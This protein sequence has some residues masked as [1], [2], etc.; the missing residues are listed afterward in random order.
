MTFQFSG[1]ISPLRP[2]LNDINAYS[3][4]EVISVT[5]SGF[6]RWLIHAKATGTGTSPLTDLTRMWS[7]QTPSR[8]F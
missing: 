6:F 8:N 2:C 4:Y 7:E 3:Q 5:T 1:G